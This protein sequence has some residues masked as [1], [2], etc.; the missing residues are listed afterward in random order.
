MEEIDDEKSRSCIDEI[1]KDSTDKVQ[2]PKNDKIQEATDE[3]EE[4]LKM[5]KDAS[6]QMNYETVI[7]KHD[8]KREVH[9]QE[10]WKKT[11]GAA[12]NKKQPAPS[13]ISY[14]RKDRNIKVTLNI[15][16]Q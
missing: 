2:F 12:E 11:H 14:N 4:M 10:N 3:L 1:L 16:I 7:K 6:I 15:C 5:K 9:T 13:F 8:I